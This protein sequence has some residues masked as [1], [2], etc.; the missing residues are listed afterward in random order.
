MK[1]DRFNKNSKITVHRPTQR[2]IPSESHYHKYKDYDYFYDVWS[3]IHYGYLGLSV[4]F[5]EKVLLSGSWVQQVGSDI[6]PAFKEKRL[7][8]ADTLD[9]HTYTM[10]IN[11]GF[12]SE[13]ISIYQDLEGNDL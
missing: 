12:S 11:T 1:D 8:R 10:R 13:K 2:G 9:D 6:K 3:N 4:G 5:S 7:P